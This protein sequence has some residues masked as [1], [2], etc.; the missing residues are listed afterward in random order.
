MSRKKWVNPFNPR[1]GAWRKEKLTRHLVL[2]YRVNTDGSHQWSVVV[3]RSKGKLYIAGSS[4][5][6]YASMKKE[7]RES[8]TY[9][10]KRMKQT[11]ELRKFKVRPRGGWSRDPSKSGHGWEL[12]S[13]GTWG[14]EPDYYIR[15]FKDK[16]EARR[17]MKRLSTSHSDMRY[18][19]RRRRTPARRFT[20]ENR[21]ATRRWKAK[22]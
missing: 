18:Y 2:E 12:W 14:D 4:S 16:G 11:G 6:S 8:A 10:L 9:A 21:R 7:A 19:L 20:Y 1:P 15:S 22:D 5:D 13:K 3:P 17:Y